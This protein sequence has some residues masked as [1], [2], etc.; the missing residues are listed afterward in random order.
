MSLKCLIHMPPE[1]VSV[2]KGGGA[3]WNDECSGTRRYYSL[4]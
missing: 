4:L 2:G 3:K 1:K